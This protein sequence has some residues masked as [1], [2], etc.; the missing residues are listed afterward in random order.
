M[1]GT[2][3][4][5]QYLLWDIL[6]I[7]LYDE[8]RDLPETVCDVVILNYARVFVHGYVSHVA[9]MT[10]LYQAYLASPSPKGRVVFVFP[11]S[12]PPPHIHLFLRKL[13]SIE[14]SHRQ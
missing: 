4:I 2:W 6:C 12:Y 13:S 11:V 10:P 7:L 9:A 8:R 3:T 1:N 5:L 14:P